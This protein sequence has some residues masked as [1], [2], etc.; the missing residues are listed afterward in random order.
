MTGVSG[1]NIIFSIQIH[2]NDLSLKVWSS[3]PAELIADL[4][5]QPGTTCQHRRGQDV[6]SGETLFQKNFK[7]FQKIFKKY[8]KNFQKI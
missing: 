7:E 4:I 6:F 3:L 1:Y 2:S 5:S 8:L